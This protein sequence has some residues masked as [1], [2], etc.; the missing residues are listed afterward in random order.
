M[1]IVLQIF[2]DTAMKDVSHKLTY[3][4]DTARLNEQHAAYPYLP[5]WRFPA[6]FDILQRRMGSPYTYDCLNVFLAIYS[7]IH[8]NTTGHELL[9]HAVRY[10]DL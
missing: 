2:P 8:Y 5:H 4:P 3:K 7:S 9:F 1:H 6:H 10:R